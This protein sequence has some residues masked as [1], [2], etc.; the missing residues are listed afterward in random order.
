MNSKKFEYEFFTALFK[1]DNRS[2]IKLLDP[3]AGNL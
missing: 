3:F 1:Y 2:V